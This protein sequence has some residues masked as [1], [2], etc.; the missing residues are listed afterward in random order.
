MK[1][2]KTKLSRLPGTSHASVFKAARYEYHKIQ[3][4]TPRREPNIRSAYFRKDKVFINQFW[5]HLKQK[6]PGD[7]LRRAKLFSCAIDLLLHSTA[8]PETVNGYKDL[9]VS[10]HRF[11]GQSNDGI[12]FCVQ[13]RENKRNNRKDFMSVFPIK[14]SGK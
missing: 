9:H 7:Q 11:Y 3:K 14:E 4:R 8:G 10:L 5:E 6:S 2:Y 13:V 1:F 12:K